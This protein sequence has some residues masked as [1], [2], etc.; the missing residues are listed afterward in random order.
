VPSL[1]ACDAAIGSKKNIQI[2]PPLPERDRSKYAGTGCKRDVSRNARASRAQVSSSKST[3]RKKQRINAEDKILPTCVGPNAIIAPQVAFDYVIV[4][5]NEGL[6]RAL[7]THLTCGFLQTPRTHSLAHA[8][9]Y[10]DRPVLRFS[11]RTGN[12]SKRP[13]KIRRNRAILST[14][15]EPLVTPSS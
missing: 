4:H 5:G 2:G 8:G 1:R 6:V 7:A 3:A 12:T 10:P 14:T 11:H 13:A 9:A 15:D